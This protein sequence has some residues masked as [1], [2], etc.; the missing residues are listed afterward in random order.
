MV[1]FIVFTTVSLF[2]ISSAQAG[3]YYGYSWGIKVRRSGVQNAVPV[4]SSNV[5]TKDTGVNAANKPLGGPSG[6]DLTGGKEIMVYGFTVT[7]LNSLTAFV[8]SGKIEE[9]TDNDKKNMI[10]FAYNV[11][12]NDLQ[13]KTCKKVGN[14]KKVPISLQK[15]FGALDTYSKGDALR[16]KASA[17]L[18]K[19]IESTMVTKG[20]NQLQVDSLQYSQ[21]SL[22]IQL[23][24]IKD[25]MAN[26][27]GDSVP[28]MMAKTDLK[29][30]N[31]KNLKEDLLSTLDK[32]ISE[33]IETEKLLI[34]D[35]FDKCTEVI[36]TSVGL[37]CIVTGNAALDI[38]NRELCINVV[39]FNRKL[40]GMVSTFKNNVLNQVVDL[41][42][43]IVSNNKKSINDIVSYAQQDTQILFNDKNDQK[44]KSPINECTMGLRPAI[45][46]DE[47]NCSLNDPSIVTA[48]GIKVNEIV[49]NSNV[50]DK[51]ALKDQLTKDFKEIFAGN[52]KFFGS[53]FL[54]KVFFEKMRASVTRLKVIDEINYQ[55]IIKVKEE[56]K[57]NLKSSYG[58][59]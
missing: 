43:A 30:Y 40:S 42:G 8:P 53:Y 35:V 55:N 20:I 38:V 16:I 13:S 48:V 44:W 39:E 27:I 26:D 45:E 7:D 10:G 41:S 29:K 21:R 36:L 4:A 58:I 22:D 50:V 12:L 54:R 17:V 59:K 1:N 52:D 19:D 3:G 37:A 18:L 11:M 24:N 15:W 28:V 9:I 5:L 46:N 6:L 25:G 31:L 47:V 56:T 32:I 14:S 34:Q 57:Y 49:V 23:G 2:L 33:D 51:Q